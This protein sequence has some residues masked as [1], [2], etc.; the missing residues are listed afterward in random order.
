[1]S[2][3]QT[4]GR[5]VL[6]TGASAGIGVAIARVFAG[7]GFDAVLTARREDRLATV[8]KELEKQYGVKA[9]AKK[10]HWKT[11][12]AFLEVMVGAVVHMT[13]L[14]EPGMK[15]R[16]F[17][18]IINVAS[19]AGLL[20]G[21]AGHTLYGAAKAFLVKFSESLALEHAGDG[22]N[23][24][25][26]CPGFTFSEFHDVLGNRK[27]VSKLPSL[28]WMDAESVARQ[29][30]AAVMSGKV[31]CVPGVVNQAIASATKL[32]PESLALRIMR[33]QTSKFRVGCLRLERPSRRPIPRRCGQRG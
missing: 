16:R 13:H 8:G 22:V 28:L 3:P 1:M 25:A 19:L 10:S 21:S 31:L 11:H 30:Y 20:P 29:G 18:R 32:V 5:T 33:T 7:H 23:V 14:F 6:V 12:R 9:M 4:K 26:L 24:T 17:G 2:E 15:E 27:L